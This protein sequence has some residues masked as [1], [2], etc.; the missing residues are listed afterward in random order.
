[1]F[2]HVHNKCVAHNNPSGGAVT[3]CLVHDGSG[4]CIEPTTDYYLER[5][6]PVIFTVQTTPDLR[7]RRN[8][9]LTD[10]EKA[11][12]QYVTTNIDM[13]VTCNKYLN[14]AG[15]VDEI[16]SGQIT[17]IDLVAF[18]KSLAID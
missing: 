9:G 11:N 18:A 14:A 15:P 16:T 3:G 6:T 13:T 7:V 17:V 5:T 2:S 10:A 4:E 1:V 12:C 8:L